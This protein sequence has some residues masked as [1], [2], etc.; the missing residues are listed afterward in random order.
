MRPN[1]RPD[2]YVVRVTNF[3]ATEPYE[4]TVTFGKTPK[5]RNRSKVERWT[6]VCRSDDGRSHDKVRVNRGQV[7]QV[8]LRRDCG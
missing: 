2:D 7:K 5:T 8:D 1:L 4:G 3:A 6:L